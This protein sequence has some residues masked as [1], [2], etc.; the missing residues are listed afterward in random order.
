MMAHACILTWSIV[1]DRFNAEGG[2]MVVRT[3]SGQPTKTLLSDD[4]R[5]KQYFA[6]IRAIPCLYQ[7]PSLLSIPITGV[8]DR[9]A[10]RNNML[11]DAALMTDIA[12]AGSLAKEDV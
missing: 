8:R 6:A 4:Q 9:N 12:A 7:R 11:H 2:L 5:K 1:F 10:L 3:A